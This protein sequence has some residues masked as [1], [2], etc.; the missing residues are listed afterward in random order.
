MSSLKWAR[1]FP[2]S[3][4]NF[5]LVLT[6]P[7]EIDSG[8][9]EKLLEAII[10]EK[11][12]NL[13]LNARAYE[14]F[15]RWLKNP[16]DP[17]RGEAYVLLSNWFM[18]NSGDRNSPV[19]TQC[20]RLW[21]ALFPCR[22]LHRLSSPEAGRNHIAIPLEFESFWRRIREAQGEN[23]GADS[24]A[25]PEPITRTSGAVNLSTELRSA[26]GDQVRAKFEKSGVH[27]EMEGSPRAVA[28]FFRL[29]SSGDGG[30][31]DFSRRG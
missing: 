13:T 25:S 8:R 22:P 23:P 1:R 3:A 4:N 31:S 12:R 5:D 6:N 26:P 24:K 19:A 21:D 28:D 18:T 11:H 20:E 27:C 2:D 16:S 10:K 15:Q 29:L 9:L 14:E 30:D 17:L 7:E